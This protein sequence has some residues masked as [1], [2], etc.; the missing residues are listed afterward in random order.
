MRGFACV[1]LFRPKTSENVGGVL[2]A[3]HCYGVAQVNIHGARGKAL[4]HQCNTTMAHRHIPTFIVDDVLQYVPY[5]CQVVAVDLCDGAEPL[6]SFQHPQR[7]MYVFGPEDGTLGKRHTDRAQHTVF[8]PT[9]GCMNLAAAV[10][11][12]LYDRLLKSGRFDA[13]Y[14]RHASSDQYVRGAE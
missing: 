7:A 1:G 6:T 3:A 8:I 11:V 13:P 12:V 4:S 10:N 5:D 2:R 9:R 14:E